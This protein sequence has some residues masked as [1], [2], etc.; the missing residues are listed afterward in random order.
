VEVDGETA[1]RTL[2][3][4][5]ATLDVCQIMGAECTGEGT[6]DDADVTFCVTSEVEPSCGAGIDVG[7]PCTATGSGADAFGTCTA[8]GTCGCGNDSECTAAGYACKVE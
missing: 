3:D 4:P 7:E 6:G 5:G 1:C 2:C 8:E